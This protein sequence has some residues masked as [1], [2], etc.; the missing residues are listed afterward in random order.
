MKI[1]STNSEEISKIK[2]KIKEIHNDTIVCNHLASGYRVVAYIKDNMHFFVGQVV[3]LEF[4]RSSN[5][6]GYIVADDLMEEIYANVLEAQHVVSDGMMYTSLVLENPDTKQ[7]MYSL[8][9]SS[10][11]LF[12]YTSIIVKGDKVKLMVNNGTVFTVET[13]IGDNNGDINK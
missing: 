11:S 9:P 4:K 1:N 7:R 5:G 13:L 2:V 12:E 3:M 6:G 10:N 8:V